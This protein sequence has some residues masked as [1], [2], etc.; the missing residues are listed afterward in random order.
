MRFFISMILVS[1]VLS[2][3][4]QTEAEVKAQDDES[5]KIC[6][7]V[8]DQ[9]W[10]NDESRSQESSKDRCKD[11]VQL[12]TGYGTDGEV[13]VPCTSGN[14]PYMCGLHTDGAITV[15]RFNGE[16]QFEIY[17]QVNQHARQGLMILDGRNVVKTTPEENTW[18]DSIYH[19][20]VGC[21]KHGQVAIPPFLILERQLSFVL[22]CD[23]ISYQN[24]DCRPSNCSQY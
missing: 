22:W 6:A 15:R 12:F 20:N 11:R 16:T 21:P 10:H 1:C 14:M 9:N 24:V 18:C 5:E 2:G 7:A 19:Q 13:Q 4:G 23:S 8:T 3:C 17:G